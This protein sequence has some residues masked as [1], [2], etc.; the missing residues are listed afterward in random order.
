[1]PGFLHQF[2]IL[3]KTRNTIYEL[4]HKRVTEYLMNI[5]KY[6]HHLAGTELLY[7]AL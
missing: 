3:P 2:P 6:M 4:H 5:I 7:P 1:M